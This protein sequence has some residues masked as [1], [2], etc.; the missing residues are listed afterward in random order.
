MRMRTRRLER[1]PSSP[2]T[3][4]GRPARDDHDVLN[5]ILSVLIDNE[6]WRNHRTAHRRHEEW[7]TDGSLL[8]R[9]RQHAVRLGL[10]DKTKERGVQVVAWLERAN[11]RR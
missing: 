2:E 3:R 7:L 1:L 10:E 5:E 6:P 9:L 8:D 11:N 4:A